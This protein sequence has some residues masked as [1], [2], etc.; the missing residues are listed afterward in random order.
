MPTN[1]KLS[2][3]FLLLLLISFAAWRVFVDSPDS[4]CEDRYEQLQARMVSSGFPKDGIPAID[5]PRFVPADQAALPD[6]EW[7]L[8][9]DLPG[10]TAAFPR[11]ILDWHEIVN[12]N[13]NGETLAV[14]YC[15]LSRSGV[16]FR[17]LRLGVTGRILNSN[18]VAY[19]RETGSLLPQIPGIFISGPLCG[20]RPERHP[21]TACTWADW[22]AA[23]PNT[24]ALSRNTGYT[25][26]YSSGSP[27]APYAEY[28]GGDESPFP[29]AARSDALAPKTVVLGFERGGEF[30][31]VPKQGF[32]ERHP[33][34]LALRLGG[35]LL[36]LNW[37][38]ALKTV[39]AQGGPQGME[40]F[41]FAWYAAHPET[42]LEM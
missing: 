19:E 20:E 37:D 18:L 12:L 41:W 27:Q 15:P 14:T 2:A 40:V 22:R 16:A 11:R 1:W 31:A 7:V 8:G 5:S 6:S 32:A 21:L 10:L 36:L 30:L 17:G 28:N 39:A 3:A 9:L 34:G 35:S 4:P 33:Q 38:P 42:R 23:H 25:R 13:L 26:D 24:L 29:L